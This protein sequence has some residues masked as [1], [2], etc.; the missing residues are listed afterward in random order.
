MCSS[1]NEGFTLGNIESAELARS[2]TDISGKGKREEG[3]GV[4]SEISV[5]V[6]GHCWG[7]GGGNEGVEM[8]G[9]WLQGS[10]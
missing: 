10:S 1:I 5:G 3:K 9:T 7:K 8:V 2:D 4:G 6:T